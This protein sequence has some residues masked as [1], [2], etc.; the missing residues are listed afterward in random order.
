MSIPTIKM[1]APAG[2]GGSILTANSGTVFVQ[3][4][5]TVSVSA[6]DAADLIKLG[7]QWAVVQH[8]V[9]APPA[10]PAALS[11]AGIV[12]SVSIS[13]GSTSLTIAAQPD[14]PRQLQVLFACGS[15]GL[16]GVMQ[17]TYIANDGTSVVDS[18]AFASA[19][20]LHAGQLGVTLTTSKAVETLT[21]AFVLGLAGGSALSNRGVQIGTNGFIGVPVSSRFVDF[22][23]TKEMV[24][25]TTVT[26]SS[27][28]LS[29]AS[30]EAVGSVIPSGALISPTTSLDGT[31]LFAFN[32]NQTLPA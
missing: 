19:A 2:F 20:T 17:L 23:V 16:S 4:D 13:P 6:L 18:L 5:G 31:H 12:T 14:V 25:T 28:G 26:S 21:S 9:Y 11:V 1:F 29:T 32:Y 30:D 15:P 22:A 27:Q 24:I 10:A 3:A 8:G 7:F